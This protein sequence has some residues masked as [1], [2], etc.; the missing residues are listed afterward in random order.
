MHSISSVVII[1]S[2]NRVIDSILCG[3]SNGHYLGDDGMHTYQS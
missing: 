1:M 3:S 2:D